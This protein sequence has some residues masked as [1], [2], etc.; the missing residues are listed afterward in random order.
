MDVEVGEKLACDARVLRGDK[1][2]FAQRSQGT[3]GDV[4]E[5]A[6]GCGDEV[7]RAHAEIVSSGSAV[8]LR[9]TEKKIRHP[10][11]PDSE[12]FGRCSGLGCALAY[13][14]FSDC[15]TRV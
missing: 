11:V 3:G 7:Q 2:H 12:A 6:D 15:A 14:H 13:G 5:V 4:L 1:S 9:R 10:Q 8:G